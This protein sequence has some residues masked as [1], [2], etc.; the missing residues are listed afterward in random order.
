MET[1]THI[2]LVTKAAKLG[3]IT[4]TRTTTDTCPKSCAFLKS[5]EC[6]DQH[7]NSNIHRVKHDRNEYTSYSFDEFLA[8]VRN[9]TATFRG[10]AGGD[11]WGKGDRIYRRKL[12]QFANECDEWR[13]RPIIYTHKPIKGVHRRGSEANRQGN[14]K[15]LRLVQKQSDEVTVNVSCESLKEADRAVDL[16]LD[17]V[18]VLPH[19]ANDK[20]HVSFTPGGK[21]ILHCPAT[22][23][24]VT[25][26][27]TPFTRA[28]GNGK[29]ICT[30][31]GHPIVGFP[32]HG[33]KKLQ[34]TKR[35]KILNEEAR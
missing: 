29:A 5:K 15:A 9:F 22:W 7:G 17:A 13:R 28:C 31:R 1:R 11:L 2:V 6:Y 10:F 16:G 34:I 27:G 30:Q 18:V 19:D 35:L 12:S 23:D 21:K 26:G 25:C 20:G 4:S 24:N 14:L 33:A 3:Y 32:G 8:H